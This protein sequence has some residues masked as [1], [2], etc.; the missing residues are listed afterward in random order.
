M[1]SLKTTKYKKHI[2]NKY[3]LCG[4][5]CLDETVNMYKMNVDNDDDDGLT[6]DAKIINSVMLKMKQC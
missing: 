3:N 4:N 1:F 6:G 5:K 2:S